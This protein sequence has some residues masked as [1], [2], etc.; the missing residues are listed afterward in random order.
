MCV[1]KR[2]RSIQTE[3]VCIIVCVSERETEGGES[4]VCERE[5]MR[6]CVREREK[7]VC[8]FER[9]RDS[10]C[11]CVCVCVSERKKETKRE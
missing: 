6:E 10:V 2:E 1:C 11:V 3:R 7:C 4:T 8:V 5:I 9:D